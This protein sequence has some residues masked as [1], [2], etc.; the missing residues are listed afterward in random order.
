MFNSQGPKNDQFSNPKRL[1]IPRD[2]GFGWLSFI[3]VFVI[4]SRKLFP[5]NGTKDQMQLLCLLPLD[6]GF[7]AETLFGS[8][9]HSQEGLRFLGFLATGAYFVSEFPFG[10]SIIRFAI[11]R[12]NTGACADQLINQAIIDRV[13]RYVLRE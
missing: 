8:C 3:R 11:V 13:L 9:H 2:F 10:N 4:G 12:P 5:V 6:A 1:S 7:G